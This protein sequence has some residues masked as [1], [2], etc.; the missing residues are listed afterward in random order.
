MTKKTIVNG[1][2][3]IFLGLGLLRLSRVTPGNPGEIFVAISWT[4][5]ELGI[6]EFLTWRA[7][8]L[9]AAYSKWSAKQAE[10]DRKKALLEVGYANLSR[11]EEQFNRCQKEINEH[12]NNVENRSTTHAN[13]EAIV[14]SAKR[15][16]IDGYNA[17]I[18]ENR[19]RLSVS[20]QSFRN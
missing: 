13:L 4:L 19:G 9:Y 16:V 6:L 11:L 10:S 15:S 18:A 5:V 3:L 2:R 12:I 1:G 17:G 7:A 14:E 8:L 20:N